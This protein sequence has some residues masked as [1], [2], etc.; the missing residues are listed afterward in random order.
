[1]K[2]RDVM[3]PEVATARPDTPM[4]E[5]AALLLARGI[6]AVPIVD[7]NGAPVGMVSEGDLVGRDES[8]RQARRTGG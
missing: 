4:R 8:A 6:S 2:V 7:E 3:T 5:I 1:M